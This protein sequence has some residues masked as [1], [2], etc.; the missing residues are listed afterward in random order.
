MPHLAIGGVS[1]ANIVELVEA[2]V[3]GVAA[4]AAVCGAD[5]PAS[6]VRRLREAIEAVRPADP[7]LA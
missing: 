6:V 1:P 5:D 3:R 4:S 2:G 7:T